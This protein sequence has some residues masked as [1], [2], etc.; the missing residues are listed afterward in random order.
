MNNGTHS[1]DEINNS[2]PQG[3]TLFIQC[4]VVQHDDLGKPQLETSDDS[5][6]YGKIVMGR[7][8]AETCCSQEGEDTMR[9]K[10]S[11]V[12]DKSLG[13]LLPN[14]AYMNN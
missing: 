9:V 4:H 10:G 7:C 12:S 3:M 1:D 2:L 8:K 11:N 6:W 13:T 5:D 14:K